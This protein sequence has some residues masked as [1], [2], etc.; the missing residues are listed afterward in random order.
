[1]MGKFSKKITYEEYLFFEKKIEIKLKEDINN[2]EQKNNIV[3]KIY[4]AFEKSFKNVIDYFDDKIKKYDN[5]INSFNN[6]DNNENEKKINLDEI[7]NEYINLQ[8]NEKKINSLLNYINKTMNIINELKSENQ[9]S[10]FFQD[11]IKEIEN[12]KKYFEERRI[13]IPLIG[14]YSV[15]K[16]SLLNSFLEEKI[17]ETSDSQLKKNNKNKEIK[18][19]IYDYPESLELINNSD[20]TTN[21]FLLIRNCEENNIGIWKAK[22]TELND[23]IYF[24]KEGNNL[25]SSKSSLKEK[26]KELNKINSNEISNENNVYYIMQYPI[27]S[28]L[29][30][31][32]SEEL[33]NKIEFID[34]PGLDVGN[35]F[36]EENIF[37]K[38]IASSDIFLYVNNYDLV[39]Q[40]SN[41]KILNRLIKRIKLRKISFSLD[42]SLFILNK[43]D[44]VNIDIDKAQNEFR[45]ALNESLNSVWDINF[46]FKINEINND[47]LNIYK[48]SNNFFFQHLE[49]S[50]NFQ[51]ILAFLL[52]I[53]KNIFYNNEEDLNDSNFEEYFKDEID[54]LFYLF[55]NYENY[56]KIKEKKENE[57]STADKDWVLEFLN[58]N[59][60]SKEL[61]TEIL[62]KFYWMKKNLDFHE[63]YK[64]QKFF[65]ESLGLKINSLE[66]KLNKEYLNEINEINK[67][68]FFVFFLLKIKLSQIKIFN[69][70]FS[71]KKNKINEKYNKYLNDIEVLFEQKEN[72]F[73]LLIDN[74][75]EKI[76]RKEINKYIDKKSKDLKEDIEK[77]INEMTKKLNEKLNEFIKYI[78]NLIKTLIEEIKNKNKDETI[79]NED[80]NKWFGSGIH[81]LA[82]GGILVIEIVIGFLAPITFPFI[83]GCAVAH[84]LIALIPFIRDSKY[85]KEYYIENL[86]EYKKN[87]EKDLNDYKIVIKENFT[88]LYNDT[89]KK[90]DL[91]EKGI[92]EELKVSKETFENAYNQYQNVLN[93]L[94]ENK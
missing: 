43:C 30:M 86:K 13:R 16:S 44:N 5:Y 28:F 46:I 71:D 1:M 40:K 83:A 31:K 93:E 63:I 59:K 17:L 84:A 78:K 24:E 27:K 35:K 62:N 67:N 42:D 2:N 75:I 36:F 10:Q 87:L 23:Y 14:G 49:F 74:F 56:K 29:K 47:K 58:A 61:D 92:N 88:K 18:Y 20:I 34:Y 66:D 39:N 15:G 57:F 33:I 64:D 6:I 94:K 55:I 89:I 91:M 69:I 90:I 80:V 9:E 82:H 53:K 51:N 8:I 22:Y 4:E 79:L 48:F 32:I 68:V 81:K 60:L 19:N 54:N 37:K 7:L 25:C 77:K 41:N 73:S 3:N 45:K 21:I 76:K 85:K 70:S 26:I 38:L 11:I 72:T 52:Y 12:V 65:L 50:E